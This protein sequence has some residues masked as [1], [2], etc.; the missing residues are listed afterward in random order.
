MPERQQHTVGTVGRGDV[1]VKQLAKRTPSLG[2]RSV[3]Q[4]TFPYRLIS[5]PET[6]KR[7]VVE[8]PGRD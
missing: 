3:A 4:L 2:D 1:I 7:V 6:G 8:W 5:I